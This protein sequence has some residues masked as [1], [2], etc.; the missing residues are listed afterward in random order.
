MEVLRR[1]F[2]ELDFSLLGVLLVI[3]AYSCIALLAATNGKSGT[4]V[5]THI[6][7]KQV[8]FE[9]MGIVAMGFAA[10]FD[11]RSLRKF[12]WWL[13]GGTTF[14][15]IA[16]FAMP[17][18]QGAHSWIPLG[19]FGFQPSEFAKLAMIIAIAA[20]MANIDEQEFPDYSLKSSLP[21]W[22]MFVVPFLLTLKEPALG[23]ALVMF[24]IV[25]TMYTVY[26]KKTHFWV[27]TVAVLIFVGLLV[28]VVAA[29]STQAS[30]WLINMEEVLVKHKLMHGYQLDRIITWLNPNYDLL[31]TGFNVHHAFLAVGSG[32]VFG[33]GLFNGSQTR[34]GWV[35]NQWTDYIFTA[36]A[37]EF[38]FVGSSTLVLLFLMLIYR[39]V[40]AGGSAQ[41]SFGTY[42]VMGIVGMFAFQV[43]ENIGM[44]MYMSPSTGITLP[45][46][47]YGGSSLIANYLAVGLVISVSIRKKKLRFS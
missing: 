26:A 42:L 39:L 36:I 28:V 2:R 20:Y 31:N 8:L 14:L 32:Q 10:A 7:S 30:N 5:P 45:F 6:V 47:S 29:Y 41:D 1:N 40:K 44:D 21:I 15:L 16:V 4:D 43:F 12:R 17:A 3:A 37:E 35:P 46:V 18:H 23:Q 24:A 34:G 27:L 19:L 33:E 11:Y 22:G 13:Y 25:L 38:G 9:F